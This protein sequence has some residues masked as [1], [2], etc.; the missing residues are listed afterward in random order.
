MQAL[1]PWNLLMQRN[2][3]GWGGMSTL[4]LINGACVCVC[5][6]VCVRERKPVRDTERWRDTGRDTEEKRDRRRER[7]VWFIK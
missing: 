4:S 6:R 1:M 3:K 2:E 7:N 5:V